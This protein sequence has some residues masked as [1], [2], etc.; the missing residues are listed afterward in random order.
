MNPPGATTFGPADGA[1]VEVVGVQMPHDY[2]AFEAWVRWDARFAFPRQYLWSSGPDTGNNIE[3]AVDAAGILQYKIYSPPPEGTAVGEDGWIDT[4]VPIVDDQW[5]LLQ[6]LTTATSQDAVGPA[7]QIWIDGVIQFELV[8]V[9]IEAPYA[10]SM[11]GSRFIGWDGN[12][13]TTFGGNYANVVFYNGISQE[14]IEAHWAARLPSPGRLSFRTPVSDPDDPD[15]EVSTN[16][17]NDSFVFDGGVDGQVVVRDVTAP[18]GW[19]FDDPGSVG[20]E[21]P[22]GPPGADG[23]DGQPGAD[24]ADGAQGDTGP[25]GGILNDQWVWNAAATIAALAAGR[26]GVN[27]DTPSLAT[28]VWI[29][30]LA[31]TSAGVDWTVVISDLAAGDKL[32]IQKKTDGTVYARYTVTGAPTLVNG[33]TYN[34]P[35]VWT[36]GNSEPAN[37]NDVVVAFQRLEPSPDPLTVSTI[38]GGTGVTS[39]LTLKPT[40]GVGAAGSDI[41]FKTGT[42]GATEAL[43]I[44]QDGTL[45][46][47][48]SKWITALG[49]DAEERNLIRLVSSPANHIE[50]GCGSQYLLTGVDNQALWVDRLY[51]AGELVVAAAAYFAFNT[52]SVIRSPS[53]GVWTL[54]NWNETDF[55]RIQLGG[56][57]AS[58]PSLKRVGADLAARLADDSANALFR[59]KSLAIDNNQYIVGRNAANSA[60]INMFKVNATNTIDVGAALNTANITA[61]VVTGTQMTVTGTGGFSAPA[62]GFHSIATRGYFDASADGVWKLNIA[63]GASQGRLGLAQLGLTDGITAPTAVSGQALLFVDT[64]DGNLKVRYGGGITRTIAPGAVLLEQKI[65]SASATLDFTAGI[66]SAYDDYLI[67]IIDI[68]PVTTAVVFSMQFSLNGGSSWETTSYKHVRN[69]MSD[70]GVSGTQIDDTP[71]VGLAASASNSASGGISGSLRFHDPLAAAPNKVLH[72]RTMFLHSSGTRYVYEHRLWYLGAAVNAIRFLMSSGNIASG[73]VRLYGIT[74]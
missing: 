74:K 70:A 60:D 6:W 31:G 20:P 58:F 63:S 47:G 44:K 66:T 13:D 67:E 36:A 8:Y 54:A 33:T 19:R 50:L 49:S 9:A 15:F 3:L 24:G 41:L 5:H 46:I 21:G 42:D 39:T 35:A 30:K 27:H 11:I 57:S 10:D 53:D 4:G 72:G 65:A 51:T 34:I 29:H 73:T 2:F 38:R 25:A 12:A 55:N 52:R 59:S 28:A 26:V 40:S 61:Q 48:E 23:A 16:F 68:I 14:T 45:R 62:G 22:Q 71:L 56:V 37:G 64:A 1:G 32:Y 69:Y 17:M 7:V 43:R 18:D